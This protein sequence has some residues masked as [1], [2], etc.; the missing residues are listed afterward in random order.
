MR[1]RGRRRLPLALASPMVHSEP[2]HARL[3]SYP[4]ASCWQH[5]LGDI[6]TAL[7]KAGLRIDELREY[8]HANGCRVNPSLVESEGRRWTWPPGVARV[9]L[10]FALRAT[11]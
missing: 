10:M 3:R 5:G 2:R 11:A 9:P 6:V 7:A 4:R 1:E 8:P